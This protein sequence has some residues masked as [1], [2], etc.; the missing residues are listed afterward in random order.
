MTVLG[1]RYRLVERLGAGGMAVVWRAYDEV[2]D[3][4]VAIKV[5][6][7]RLAADPKFRW[8]L[9]A[10]AQAAG[11]LCHPHITNVYDYGE[12]D[13]DPGPARSEPTSEATRT[14]RSGA[15]G[16]A[17]AER[18]PV[19]RAPYV[20]MEIVDGRS[21]A[22]ALDQD[23][24][25]PWPEAVKACA[26]V[27]SALAVAH[28]N[29]VVH[30]D[31]KPSNVMLTAGG[32]K[33]VDFGISAL[34]GANDVTPEGNLLGTPAYLAPERLEG[35]QVSPA[36]DVYALGLLLYRALTGHL[37]WE[38]ATTT[39]M[40][41]A[42]RYSDPGPLPHVE[43]LPEAV[44]L[45][46]RRCLAKRPETRPS[47]AEAAGVLASFSTPSWVPI[48]TPA[49]QSRSRQWAGAVLAAT[50]L[51]AVT[52]GLWVNGN[53]SPSGT[54]GSGAAAAVTLPESTAKPTAAC[55]VT[56]SLRRDSGREFH[57][58]VTVTNAGRQRV[59]GWRLTFAFPGD[60]RLVDAQ[61]AGFA[62]T[63]RDVVIQPPANQPIAAGDSVAMRVTGR[64]QKGNPLPTTFAVDGTECEALVSGAPPASGGAASDD[65]DSGKGKGGGKGKSGK[66][67]KD[68]D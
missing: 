41:R 25:M 24:P 27:A 12:Q 68:D 23:G 39:Q 13:L 32:A 61:P 47:S 8:Q 4:P 6:A 37:P 1:G 21:M 43:G 53:R 50:A 62:Q 54:A 56:Y 26:E 63:G 15:W 52:G 30:R 14:D 65:D 19:S 36:T 5:L 66:G 10:E 45:L 22:A 9:R 67:G 38:V 60:Q 11:K 46:C 28:A 57:A 44:A 58:D 18:E 59:E 48:A 40:L 31:V 33:V 34:I 3:R 51:L 17:D 7:P 42:H 64:Y 20:V 49:N 35:G 29:G 16:E 55:S 2:L